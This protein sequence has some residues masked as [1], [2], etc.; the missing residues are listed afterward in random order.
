VRY[1]DHAIFAAF[2]PVESPEIVVVAVV[3]HAGGGGGAVA[4]PMAQKVLAEYFRKQETQ[5]PTQ[6]AALM[7]SGADVSG[8]Q[9]KADFKLSSSSL[10]P[11]SVSLVERPVREAPGTMEPLD[12][13]PLGIGGVR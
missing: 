5:V 10:V 4:A 3:E 12:L 2:A 6:V 11:S 7:L 8:P 1:R 13:D 9:R